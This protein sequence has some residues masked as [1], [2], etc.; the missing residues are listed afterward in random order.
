MW[1]QDL[2]LAIMPIVVAAYICRGVEKDWQKLN[3]LAQRRE[4]RLMGKLD[5]LEGELYRM[6]KEIEPL[7]KAE[8]EREREGR[9][10]Q[11]E[12]ESDRL[13]DEIIERNKQERENT[14]KSA[15]M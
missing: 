6:R 15:D 12:A 14:T 9:R 4:I 1:Y 11:W 10:A 7:R 5:A 3:E 2:A 8:E 13:W